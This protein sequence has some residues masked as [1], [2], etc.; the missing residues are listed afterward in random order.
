MLRNK[1]EVDAY[2][3]AIDTAPELIRAQYPDLRKILFRYF[4]NIQNIC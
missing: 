4:I 2:E 3:S 1:D